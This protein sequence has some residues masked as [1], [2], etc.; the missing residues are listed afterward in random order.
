VDDQA[1]SKRGIIWTLVGISFF[2]SVMYVAVTNAG[3]YTIVAVDAFTNQPIE[4]C[5]LTVDNDSQ[6]T[7]SAGEM[8][9]G[10]EWPGDHALLLECPGY[11]AAEATL[12][13]NQL[14][15]AD[16]TCPDCSPHRVDAVDSFW[17]MWPE[18]AVAPAG[19]TPCLTCQSPTKPVAT[20]TPYPA[21]VPTPTP[22]FQ[23][24]QPSQPEGPV[25]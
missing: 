9:K 12:A 16:I 22:V 17:E 4:G 24:G 5:T 13:V 6:G 25:I 20:P 14:A 23:N 3:N 8:F 1:I 7:R 10:W 2:L 18:E 11:E 19:T 21:G 15:M